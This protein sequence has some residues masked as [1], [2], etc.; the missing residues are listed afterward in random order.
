MPRRQPRWPNMGLNSWSCS[1]R[2]A[3]ASGLTPSFFAS[4]AWDLA[5]WGRNSWSG[6]SSRRM[7]AG[8][9]FSSVKMPERIQLKEPIP[10][11][12]REIAKTHQSESRVQSQEYQPIGSG[13]ESFSFDGALFEEA[14]SI[15]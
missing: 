6:G 5:S 3:M 2:W 11:I 7:V 13:I 10:A 14:R 1:T 4:S 9:P 12:S 8:R 15:S